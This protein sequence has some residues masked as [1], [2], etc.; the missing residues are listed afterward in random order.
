MKNHLQNL[1]DAGLDYLKQGFSIIPVQGKRPLVKWK[2]LQ[3]KQV[4]NEEFL[5]WFERYP[6]ITGIALVINSPIVVLDVEKDERVEDLTLPE[7]VCANSGGGGK[8]YYFLYSGSYPIGNRTRIAGRRIDVRA[9]GGVIIL[10][11]SVHASGSEYEWVL[12][13][14]LEKLKEFPESVLKLL[15]RDV[16]DEKAPQALILEGNRNDTL[17][18]ELGKMLKSVASEH[19][20][21]LLWPRILV[22]NQQLCNPPLTDTELRQIFNSITEREMKTL[23]R[24]KDKKVPLLDQLMNT[25]APKL[26]FW[27]DHRKDVFIRN[28]NYMHSIS[29]EKT[30][31]SIK[32]M[33]YEKTGKFISNEQVKSFIDILSAKTN[34]SDRAFVSHVR[35]AGNPLNKIYY[36]LCDKTG[37]AIVMKPKEWTI[38]HPDIPLFRRYPHQKEQDYPFHVQ[39]NELLKLLHFIPNLKNDDEK[40]L[41]LWYVVSLFIPGFAHPLLLLRGDQGSG[42]STVSRILVSLCDPTVTSILEFPNDKREMTQT[43][44]HRYLASFDNIDRLPPWASSILCIAVTGGFTNTRKLY[45]DNDAIMREIQNAIILNGIDIPNMKADLLDRSLIIEFERIPSSKRISEKDFYESFIESKPRILGAI[46][47]TVCK[48]MAIYPTLAF[49]DLPRMADFAQWITAIAIVMGD[50]QEEA[51]RIYRRN[52]E[53]QYE[54]VIADSTLAQCLIDLLEKTGSFNGTSTDLLKELKENT[55]EHDAQALPKQANVLSRQLRKLRPTLI[56]SGINTDIGK[57]KRGIR[58]RYISLSKVA[59]INEKESSQSTTDKDVQRIQDIFTDARSLSQPTEIDAKQEDIDST[60]NS[61][62]DNDDK[63]DRS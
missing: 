48:A 57:D 38:E 24:N 41:F 5:A 23:A 10:P 33:I 27:L 3:T 19:W 2:N 8:H 18:R 54:T 22:I 61:C 35:I 34:Q 9:E 30:Q 26:D 46:L 14:Q 62:Y 31:Q 12:K 21:T 42:K 25:I 39:E 50:S 56:D 7:T 32:L 28:E 47:T 60:D 6:N 1:I 45:T 37:K 13:L 20:E 59:K 40:K 53:K 58:G 51:M 49:K 16:K 11:P 36:D 44:D 17:T 52:I 55:H 63:N 29:D 15:Y 4:T 43:L